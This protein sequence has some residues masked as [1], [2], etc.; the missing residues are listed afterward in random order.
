[1]KFASGRSIVFLTNRVGRLLSNRIRRETGHPL[2]SEIFPHMGVLVDLWYKDGLRQ[3]DLAVSAIKDKATIARSLDVLEEKQVVERQ[4]DPS[5]RRIKRIFLTETGRQ[6]GA[7]LWPAAEAVVRRSTRGI[8]PENM[9]ICREVL[10]QIF[11]NLQEEESP[12][13]RPT[14]KPGMP[15]K[16]GTEK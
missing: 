6:L 15:V 16:N 8:P 3:Q 12:S 2:L 1:M 4:A 5:D 7:E 13:G 9:A 14:Q 10:Q 11:T